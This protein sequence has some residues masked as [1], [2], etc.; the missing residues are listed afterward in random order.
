M[1]ILKF[2]FG[3]SSN[4]VE[5]EN[6]NGEEQSE[7]EHER[8]YN[9]E[10]LRDDGLRAL[11]I[12]QFSYAV[13]CFSA[14]LEYMPEHEETQGYLAEA[15]IRMGEGL[16]ALDLLD[17]LVKKYPENYKLL[18]ASAQAAEISED[19]DKM[20][21]FARAA[22]ELKNKEDDSF[23]I[24][25]RA[26]YN[27]KDYLTAVATLTQ[28]L[29]NDEHY[30]PVR[31][32]RARILYEMKQYVEAEKDIDYLIRNDVATEDVYCLKGKIREVLGDNQGALDNYTKL[33]EMN[34]FSYDGVLRAAKVYIDRNQLDKALDLLNEAIELQP[35]FSEAYKMRGN[36]KLLLHDEAGSIEDLKN[37]F[38]F[39][40]EEQKS[41]NGDFT[42]IEE[43]MKEYYRSLNP[44]GF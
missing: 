28:L 17:E 29:T 22:I 12:G 39:A 4:A 43:K 31:E 10:T 30:V 5:S 33:R 8:K 16:K 40:P 41:I 38:E 15:Y 11:D 13:R 34:P 26:Q 42:N 14:A 6:V 35:K 25:A 37:S 27:K 18:Y 3:T 24:L 20:E 23:F 21:I 7:E 44:Y 32:L 19:W 9:F 2:F 1:S 36:V